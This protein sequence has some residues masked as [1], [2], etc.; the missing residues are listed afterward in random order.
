MASPFFIDD[1]EYLWKIKILVPVD[2]EIQEQEQKV[3]Y[4]RVGNARKKELLA[5]I[6][7]NAKKIEATGEIPA[8][9]IS[10]EDLADELL[11]GWRGMKNRDGSEVEFSPERKAQFLDREGVASAIVMGWYESMET[12]KVGNSPEP[13]SSSGS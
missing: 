13:P 4:K 3:Y 9:A 11:A 2:G 10:D 5:L 8:D 7:D 12:R 1:S 6:L